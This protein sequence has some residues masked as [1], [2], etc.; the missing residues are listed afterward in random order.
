MALKLVWLTCLLGA[1]C[2]ALV[3]PPCTPQY[4]GGLPLL[5]P[6]YGVDSASAAAAAA[7]AGGG[8]NN[9]GYPYYPYVYPPVY[10]GADSASATAAAAATGVG[11]GILGVAPSAAAAASAAA[12]GG[13]SSYYGY[14]YYPSVYPP[15]YVGTDSASAAAVMGAGHGLLGTVSGAAGAGGG[16][17]YYGYLRYPCYP[18]IPPVFTYLL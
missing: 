18:N 9:Y 10:C 17:M 1:S 7:A 6:Y 4:G 11:Y 3:A 14:P 5:L 16:A 8:F 2:S 15:Y 13:G 12:T